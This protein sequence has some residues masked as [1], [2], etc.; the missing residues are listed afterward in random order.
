MFYQLNL[1]TN[2]EQITFDKLFEGINFEPITKGRLG[3]NLFYS[4]SNKIPLVRT[5]TIYTNPIQKFNS[6]H[7][8]IINQI[9]LQAKE[10][11]NLDIPELI[12][13]LVEIYTDEYKTMGFHTDQALDLEPKSY[14]CIYSFYSNPKSQSLR[15]LEIQNKI[16]GEKKSISLT[17]NSVVLF[18]LETN[19]KNLHK[20]VLS[21]SNSKSN[22]KLNSEFDFNLEDQNK[23]FGLTLRTS[24]TFVEF[25]DS[26]AYLIEKSNPEFKTE[27]KLATIEEKKEF[28]KLRSEENKSTCYL[29]PLIPYTISP[30][31]LIKPNI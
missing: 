28:Y 9:K 7:L 24:K 5:T 12:N 26:K 23:W 18:D 4:N 30:S 6:L 10:K 20:I 11:Y 29:Y 16:N 22:S 14:I 13:G 1:D 8:E 27:L 25:V 21:E 15:K 19:Q 2:Q 17:H 31:D 3:A